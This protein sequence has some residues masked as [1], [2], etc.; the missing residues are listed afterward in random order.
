MEE[1]STTQ[2]SLPGRSLNF[3]RREPGSGLQDKS[4]CLSNSR[5]RISLRSL[6]QAILAQEVS[7]VSALWGVSAAMALL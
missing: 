2:I 1:A 6:A 7:L 5:V 3:R 4:E